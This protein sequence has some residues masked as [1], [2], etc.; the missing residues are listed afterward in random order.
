MQN[1]RRHVEFLKIFSQ[2][3]FRK[4]LDAKIGAGK[5]AHHPMEPE[6]F[7]HAFR[8]LCA[9]PVIIVEWQAEIL[10]ELR[11]VGYDAGADLIERLHWRACWI[12]RRLQHQRRYCADQHGLVHTFRALPADVASNFAA[13]RRMPDMGC[14]LQVVAPLVPAEGYIHFGG[15]ECSK[16]LEIIGAQF[17]DDDGD[18]C[19]LGTE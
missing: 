16:G 2:I 6:G 5:T 4:C 8:D 19:A 7:A 13:A 14:V 10:P 12:G 17:G 15:S 11:A 3:G 18:L 9:R 1:E